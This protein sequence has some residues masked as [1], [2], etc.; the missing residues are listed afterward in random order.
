MRLTINGNIQEHPD[1]ITGAELLERIDWTVATLVA[2]VNGSIVRRAEFLGLE[3]HDGDQLEL[4]TVV[5][6]G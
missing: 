2:E 1:G 6:G 5:G 4:V 3:L